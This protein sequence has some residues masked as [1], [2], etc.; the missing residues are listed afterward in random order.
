[1]FARAE[2]LRMMLKYRNIEFEDRHITFADWPT[3]KGDKT[4]YEFGFM[5]VLTCN[6]KRH[7]ESQTIA[8]YLGTKL[9]LYNR[10]NCK[11][12]YCIDVLL[13][14]WADIQDA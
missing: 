6:G 5:P 7:G 1:M 2:V 4:K 12:A 8:R 10:A 13:S 11:E 3:V 14:V 9:G